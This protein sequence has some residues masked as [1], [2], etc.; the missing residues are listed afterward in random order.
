MQ[1]RIVS[2]VMKVVPILSS[3]SFVGEPDR[4]VDGAL[5]VLKVGAKAF[6]VETQDKVPSF[7]RC[8]QPLD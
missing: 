6:L 3:S 8:G 1:L 7:R 5:P 4:E 2:L